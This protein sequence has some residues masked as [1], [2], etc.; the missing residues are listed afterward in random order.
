V[1]PRGGFE[2][3]LLWSKEDNTPGE[4]QRRVQVE[5][6]TVWAVDKRVASKQLH[7][8]SPCFLRHRVTYA[9][10]YCC[11]SPT[12]RLIHQT[13]PVGHRCNHR[14]C[15][16]ASEPLVREHQR[17][18]GL[19]SRS[20]R[21]MASL[22]CPRRAEKRPQDFQLGASNHSCPPAAQMPRPGVAVVAERA[23][24]LQHDRSLPGL[25]ACQ[26]LNCESDAMR[27]SN[28][29]SLAAALNSE[30]GRPSPECRDQ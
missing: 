14:L 25:G 20:T 6:V 9:Y 27:P 19:D 22:P 4:A 10:C 30:A 11:Y 24:A 5:H 2:C 1:Y 3:E 17:L 18:R 8:P 28:R 26:S 13:R 16:S 7:P 12:Q 23:P 29:Q 21:F 15:L